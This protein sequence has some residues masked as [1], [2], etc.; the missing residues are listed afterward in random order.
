MNDRGL[1]WSISGVL[2]L[3]VVVGAVLSRQP[4]R[5][6]V[7]L[8][9]LGVAAA[10]GVW[11]RSPRW[12][13]VAALA[14]IGVTGALCADNPANVGLFALCV[15]VAWG[16]VTG[17]PVL[18]GA[19]ALATYVVLVLGW[20]VLSEDGGWSAWFAAT[21]VTGVVGLVLR[22]D[23]Q[24]MDA[25]RAA[26]AGLAQRAAAEERNRIAREMHDVIGHALTVSALHITS[27]RLALD[28]EPEEARASLAEAERLAQ[29]SLAEVRAAVGLMRDA[30]AMSLAP[31]P[32]ISLAPMPGTAE[33]ASLVESFR[34]AGAPVFFDVTG[35]VAAVSATGGLAVYRILQEALTNA[36]RHAPGRTTDVRVDVL[37]GRTHV[38]VDSAGPPVA[39]WSSHTQSGLTGMRER[40]EALG[41]ELTAGPSGTGWRVEAVLPT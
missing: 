34:R 25:L 20:L 15:V 29:Q 5:L 2:T 32:A 6:A 24:L 30:P 40:A 8:A 17:G 16:A 1:R 28:E 13:V 14:V 23:R 41:G 18:A 26:Q 22:R 12:N 35:D 31:V 3:F 39:S 10:V 27:A 11:L 19:M 21:L 4:P 33:L 36:T 37:A 9:V 7:A 38:V